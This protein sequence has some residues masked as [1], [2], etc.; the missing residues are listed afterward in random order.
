MANV[1]LV[2]GARSELYAGVAHVEKRLGLIVLT[3]YAGDRVTVPCKGRV[4]IDHE[5]A[6]P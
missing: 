3:F 6:D 2:T 1:R 5:G 4:E